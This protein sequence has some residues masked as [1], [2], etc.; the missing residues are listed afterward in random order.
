MATSAHPWQHTAFLLTLTGLSVVAGC[1]VP[2]PNSEDLS[3]DPKPVN[4]GEREGQKA[5]NQSLRRSAEWLWQQQADDGGW[6]SRNY[7][8]LRSGQAYTPFVLD[9]LLSIPENAVDRPP[10]G[11][12]RALKFIRGRINEVG[13]LG[14]HDPDLLEYPS[15]ATAYALRCLVLAG[16]PEDRPLIQKMRAWL[17]NQQFTEAAGYLPSNPAYGSWGFGG[18]RRSGSPG[19]LDLAHT[20]RVLQALHE[21]AAAGFGNENDRA[22]FERAERFLRMM[23]RRPDETRPQPVPVDFQAEGVVPYD[24]GFYFSPVVFAANKGGL[25]PAAQS[26]APFYRSYATTTCDGALALLLAGVNRN[27]PRIQD[28]ARWLAEHPRLDQPE[29]I[30]A[31]GSA[32]WGDA[33]HYYHFA[34]RGELCAAVDTPGE[35]RMELERLLSEEQQLDGAYRNSRSSLMKE[36]DPILAT[37]LAATALRSA[38]GW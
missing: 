14:F 7:A 23:Q 25:V 24:G 37:T 32:P 12:D 4:S 20:R 6:H 3:P 28:A 5:Q 2:K 8:L 16:Q 15:Y 10:G 9:L 29:G 34:A 19:H 27:D 26:S 18:E 30:P 11:V 13:A 31:D 1:S 35:W 22:V 21:S 33:L 17:V 38:A 36:D